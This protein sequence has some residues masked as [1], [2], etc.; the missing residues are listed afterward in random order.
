MALCLSQQQPAALSLRRVSAGSGTSGGRNQIFL[1]S[2]RE[3]TSRGEFNFRG[4]F[5]IL[6]TGS[7]AALGNQ[8]KGR[9]HAKPWSAQKCPSERSEES[10]NFSDLRFCSG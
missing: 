10:R 4:Q 7:Q 8:N 2:R 9:S 6:L 3:K 5:K 1:G